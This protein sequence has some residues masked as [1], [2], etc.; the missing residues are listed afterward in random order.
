[1]TTRLTVA[2]RNPLNLVVASEAFIGLTIRVHGD[3]EGAASGSAFSGPNC[4][5]AAAGI[6]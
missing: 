6:G 3:H 4:V 1:M 5:A 2:L